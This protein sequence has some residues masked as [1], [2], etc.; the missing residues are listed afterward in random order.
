MER[1]DT[2]FHAAKGE[3]VKSALRLILLAF[4]NVS[5]IL[6]LRRPRELLA[7]IAAQ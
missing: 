1:G 7:P 3:T 4:P 6:T 2:A 5:N